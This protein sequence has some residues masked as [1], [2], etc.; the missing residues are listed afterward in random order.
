[1]FLGIKGRIGFRGAPRA[2]HEVIQMGS[3]RTSALSVAALSAFVFLLY[4]PTI[5]YGLVFDDTIQIVGNYRLTSWSYLPGY[6]TT[7]LWAHRPGVTKWYRPLFLVWLRLCYVLFGPPANI[8]HLPSIL[9]HVGATVWLFALI[10]RLTGN[11]RSAI[12]SVAIFGIHPIHTEAVAWISAAEDPLVT[13]FLLACVYF[14]AGRKGLVSIL[15]LLCALLAMFSKEVGVMAVGLIFVYEWIRSSLKPAISASIPYLVC[16]A[17]YFAF[18]F[19]ALGSFSGAAPKYI[20]LAMMIL[21]WPLLIADY[22][23]HLLWPVHLSMVYDVPLGTR[24]WPVLLL[25]VLVALAI[26]KL[27]RADS[28][29]QFGAVW[30]VIT[31][32]PALMIWYFDNDFLHDRYLYLPSAGLAIMLSSFLARWRFKP[33]RIILLAAVAGVLCLVTLNGMP[34]WRDEVS[35]YERAIEN[36]PRNTHVLSN[37]ALAYAAQGKYTDAIRTLRHAIEIDAKDPVLYINLAFCYRSVG[38]ETD[39]DSASMVAKQLSTPSSN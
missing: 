35:L 14:Y 36:S 38:D 24:I 37:L 26:W 30:F 18:R 31:L 11:L 12:A 20:G 32:L 27:R 33:S 22:M 15:S 21:T 4:L 16:T 6:F 2:K 13:M 25:V 8:W 34:V 19:N 5:H 17:L 3:T 29:I 28:T 7:H 39:A 1:V 10:R 9:A 23:V